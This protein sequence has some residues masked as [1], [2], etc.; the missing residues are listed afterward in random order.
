MNQGH[1][2]AWDQQWEQAASYYRRA[3]QEFP[4][5]PIALTNMGLALFELK[6]HTEALTYYQK[7]ARVSENDPLPVEKIA[8]IYE[9][10]G[11]LPEAVQA[12]IQAA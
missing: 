2:A 7:A 1:S 3:L 5:N 10:L 8:R 4:D 6:K 12:S 11:K 9:R